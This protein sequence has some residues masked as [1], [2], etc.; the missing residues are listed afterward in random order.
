MVPLELHRH[1]PDCV[2]G[3]GLLLVMLAD[4]WSAS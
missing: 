1:Q 3:L 2:T 4:D